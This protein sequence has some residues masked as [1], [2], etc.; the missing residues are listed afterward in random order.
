EGADDEDR[1]IREEPEWNRAGL[2][3]ELAD[4]RLR[5]LDRSPAR[6]LD[7]SIGRGCPRRGPQLALR[8]CAPARASAP[9]LAPGAPVG[10]RRA[11]QDVRL[12]HRRPGLTSVRASGGRHMASIRRR[13]E[14]I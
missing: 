13:P 4:G 1:A 14:K 11:W 10:P 12:S 8:R 3:R 6:L 5:L 9:A 7:R 2:I